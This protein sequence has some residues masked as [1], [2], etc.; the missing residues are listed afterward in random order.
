MKTVI[1][2][3]NEFKGE[4]PH[5]EPSIIEQISTGNFGSWGEECDHGLNTGNFRFVC[6]FDKF[7]KCV[8]EMTNMN[9]K[10]VYTKESAAI[11]SL[12]HLGYT[13]HDAEFWKPPLSEIGLSEPIYSQAMV[14][15]GVM[16]SVGMEC[17]INF[18]DIDNA[19]HEYTIDFMGKHTFIASC[20]DVS[21]R[22][23][24]IEDVHIKPLTPPI[25]LIDGK[26]YQ[27]SVNGNEPIH[28]VYNRLK[29]GFYHIA[30]LYN[31]KSC[32]NIKELG[33]L[34]NE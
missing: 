15:A 20:D 30:S 29:N 14:D 24:H 23:G 25:E 10:P 18:P 7:N 12:E 5:H 2:A 8:E 34:N 31:L 3:V 26:A 16:P 27:F 9:I 17:L 28:G 6:T 19:W 13:Y 21:E 22:F 32:T 1:D 11:K 33:V 4:W